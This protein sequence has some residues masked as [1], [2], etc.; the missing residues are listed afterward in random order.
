MHLALAFSHITSSSTFVIDS[1]ATISIVNDAR[2]LIPSTFNSVSSAS[3][4]RCAGGTRLSVAGEGVLE[5]GLGKALYVPEAT[6]CL[7]S[8]PQLTAAGHTVSF[9][10]DTVRLDGEIIGS[11]I[12]KL[13]VLNSD[14]V[15]DMDSDYYPDDIL[16]ANDV[17]ISPEVD[18]EKL[19]DFNLRRDIDLLHRRFAHV[20]VNMLYAMPSCACA[21]R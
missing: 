11:L 9:V 15:S 4:V 13:Y 7:I 3:V 18:T 16:L 14:D 2:L 21:C 6:R 20:D 17:L 10:R 8:V 1:G 12:N 19:F 5:N